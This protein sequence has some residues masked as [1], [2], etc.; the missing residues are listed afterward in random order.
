MDRTAPDDVGAHYG[1]TIRDAI[2]TALICLRLRLV[3]EKCGV[4]KTAI[5]TPAHVAADTWAQRE[6]ITT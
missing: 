4:P 2:V 5:L 6:V 3:T 1:S